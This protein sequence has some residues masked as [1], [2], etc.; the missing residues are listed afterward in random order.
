MQKL[1]LEIRRG[2][3]IAL[4]IRLESEELQSVP[5][6]AISRSAPVRITAPGHALS[7][8]WRAA[9]VCAGGMSEINA[10]NYPPRDSELRQVTRIDNDVVEFNKVSSACFRA[11]SSGGYL[12]SYAPYDLSLYDGAR[13]EVKNRVGGTQLALFTTA[14][15]TL[16]LDEALGCVWLKISAGDSAALT[17][18]SGVFDIE[19]YNDDSKVTAVCSAESTFTVLPEVTTDHD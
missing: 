2:A 19:L 7:D 10:E 5:V 16:E 9:V 13:M 3:T 1:D 17:F 12:V 11:Y 18:S 4:P 8:K 15:G 14:D 6:T